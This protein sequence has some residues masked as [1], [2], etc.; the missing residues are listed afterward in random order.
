MLTWVRFLRF[1]VDTLALAVPLLLLQRRLLAD[2]LLA[3]ILP[4]KL[5]QNP[6]GLLDGDRNALVQIGDSVDVRYKTYL[7]STD[8]QN[9][10]NELLLRGISDVCDWLTLSGDMK[11]GILMADLKFDDFSGQLVGSKRGRLC[12][13]Q[14]Q[15]QQWRQRQAD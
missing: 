7:Q 1:R 2:I 10:A 12:S 11:L 15:L 9:L 4:E 13:L 3:R 6:S 14:L 5:L 8:T